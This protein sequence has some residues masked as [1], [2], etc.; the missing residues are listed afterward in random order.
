MMTRNEIVKMFMVACRKSHLPSRFDLRAIAEEFADQLVQF[1][2]KHC[3]QLAVMQAEF[4]ANI[5]AL[6]CEMDSAKLDF[7]GALKRLLLGLQ[8]ALFDSSDVIE[9]MSQ[10][11]DT[12]AEQASKWHRPKRSSIEK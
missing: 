5:A 11:A 12:H 6:R 9:S 4:E 2:D 3:K 8:G 1:N 7:D 10:P